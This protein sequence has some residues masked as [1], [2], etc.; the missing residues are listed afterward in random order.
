MFNGRARHAQRLFGIVGTIVFSV[1]IIVRV[2]EGASLSD[3]VTPSSLLIIVVIISSMFVKPPAS[4][5]QY[6]PLII[7]AAF[8]A[9]VIMGFLTGF[10]R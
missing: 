10:I 1:L 8:L 4:I 6:I 2:L 9:G 5:R 3:I 7:A